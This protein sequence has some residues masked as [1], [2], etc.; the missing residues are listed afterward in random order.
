[1]AFKIL[2]AVEAASL[3]K[4]GSVVAINGFG[5]LAQPDLFS[6][7]LKECFEKTGK[8]NDLTIVIAAGHGIYDHEKYLN[9]LAIEGLF[10][11]IIAGH[12]RSMLSIA[13]MVAKEKVEAYNIPMGI[14]SQM[15]R[16]MAGR[17]PGIISKVGLKTFVDPRLEGGKLNSI[18]KKDY[19][20]LMNIEGEDYLF[21][22]AFPVDF[23]V[24]RGTTADPYGNIT[25]EKEAVFLDA[26]SMAQAA[27]ANGG[28]VIVQVERLSAKPA[29][30]TEVKIPGVIVDAVIVAPDQRQ[31]YYEEY[32][33]YYTGEVLMPDSE[34]PAFLSEISGRTTA[35]RTI[36][37]HIIARRAEE[38]IGKE[39]VVNFGAGVPEMVGWYIDESKN[40][41]LTVES[42]ILGGIPMNGAEFGAGVNPVVIYDQPSQFDFYDGGGLD[43]TFLGAL[44]IDAKGNVNVSQAG[45][46]V[47]GIG[48]FVNISQNTKKVVYCFPFSVRG[49]E[50]EYKDGKLVIVNEGAIGKFQESIRQISFSGEYAVETGQKVLFVTERCVFHLTSEG[51]E[52]IEIAPGID[53][54]KNILE[55]MPFKVKVSENLKVMD[56]KYFLPWE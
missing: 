16:A 42:G 3:I 46:S 17:K 28:K 55:L 7:G 32:S 15:F 34:I 30:P 53:L 33:P 56:E 27:K 8:P 24:I 44:E 35:K 37:H 45:E 29:K 51:L 19:V 4:P 43:V 41:T 25:M 22:K 2:S 18:S 52:I 14:I 26:L 50:V 21:Y 12:L 6:D 9:K 23:S 48:G 31:S 20:E 47:V 13:D 10:S 40:C 38:E 54:Q 39:N 1:M 5:P 36:T 49:L 11:K